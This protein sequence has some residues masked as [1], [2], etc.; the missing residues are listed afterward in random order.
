MISQYKG[1]LTRGCSDQVGK[2]VEKAI[3][4]NPS[5]GGRIKMEEKE[6]FSGSLIETK[7]DEFPALKRS[8]SYNADR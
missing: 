4:E 8:S 5:F 6:Y 3:V 2:G 7:K 1:R